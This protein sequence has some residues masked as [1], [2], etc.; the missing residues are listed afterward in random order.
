MTINSINSLWA[1][2]ARS[3]VHAACLQ[4]ALSKYLF[5]E[6]DTQMSVLPSAWCYC[7]SFSPAP[8]QQLRWRSGQETP[9]P[10]DAFL[11]ASP[12]GPLSCP[13]K[14]PRIGGFNKDIYPLPVLEAGIPDPGVGR[15]G[16]SPGL[17]PWRV[18]GC[19]LPV[20]SLVHLCTCL[21]PD[22]LFL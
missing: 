17:S 4:K 13:N 8:L 1:L 19:L 7:P 12:G 15:A 21:C 14:A 11:S 22:F 6:S 16:S 10:Q 18:D 5:G 9:Q 2:H 20:S 3:C